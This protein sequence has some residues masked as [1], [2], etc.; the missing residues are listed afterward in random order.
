MKVLLSIMACSLLLLFAQTASN[1][2]FFFVPQDTA[3][4]D[5]TAAKKKEPERALPLKPERKIEFTTDEGT[6]LS[7]DVSPDGKTIVFELLGDLYTLP[8][9]GGKATPITSGLA[10]DSQPRFSPDGKRIVFVTDRGGS[11]NLY[12][13]EA[14]KSIVDTTAAVDSTGLKQLTKGDKAMYASPEWTPDGKY[15]VASKGS[16][17]GVYH[18]HLYHVDGGSGIDLFAK[19]KERNALGAA[20]GKDDRY[21]YFSTK[22]GRFQYNMPVFNWQM[23]IYDRETGEVFPLTGETGGAV[24]PCL[25]PDGN[26]LVYAT[27]KDAKTA[28]KVRNLQSGF[29]QWLAYPVTRD[30]QES[31][32][33][34]D[35]MP[36]YAFT[37][38]SKAI[39]A[40]VD[41]KI[42]RIEVPSGQHTQIPFGVD[43]ELELGPLSH[44]EKQVED[45]PVKVRQIR[46]A[47]IS[48]DGTHL[49]FTALHDL[50]VRNFASGKMTQLAPMAAGQ[51]GPAWSPDSKSLAFVTWSEAEGGAVYKVAV[52]GGRAQKLSQIAAYYTDPVWTPD[53]KEIVVAKGPW[54]QRQDLTIF[55][56]RGG[57]GLDLVRIPANGG[58]DALIAPLKGVRPHF[59]DKPDRIY[60]YEGRDGLVSMRLDG[61]DRKV[62]AKVTGPMPPFGG[63]EPTTAD[64]VIMGA[65]GEHVLAQVEN[66][67][68]RITVPKVGGEPPTVSILSPESATFP[69]EKLSTVGALFMNFGPNDKEANWSL[70]N[71]FFRYNFDRAKIFADSIKAVAAAKKDKS[72]KEDN[73]DEKKYEPFSI[74][75]DLEAPRLKGN[76]TVVLRGAKILTMTPGAA[77]DGVIENGAVVIKDNRID[78]VGASSEITTPDGAREIDVNGKFILPGFVDTHAHMW[79]AWGV[80]RGVVWEYLA[81]VAYGVLTTRDPQTSTTDVLTY[82]DLVETGELLGPRVY[83]TGPGVFATDGIKSLKDAQ[84]VLKR[85]SEYYKINTIKQYVAGDRNTR[86]W[87]IMAAKEQGLIPTTEGALDMKLDLSQIIDGYPGN[88]HSFPIMP[89]YK[90]V[91]ELVAKSHTFYTPT[92][93]VS[94]GGPWAENYYYTNTD[95]HDDAKLRK[96]VPHNEIDKLTRRRP[97]FHNDE[98]VYSQLAAQAKK[99]VEAGGRVC[100]GS[101]GQLQGLGYHWELWA[102]QSG[103][104]SEMDALRCATIFGAESIG[105]DKDL[106]TIA[107]GK[108]ADLIVLEK[109]PL[110][111]IHNT[112]TIQYV[113]KNGLLYD[114]NS[115]NQIW[116]EEKMLPKPY[117]WDHEPMTNGK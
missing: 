113:M 29:E 102:V 83:Y 5:T 77:N 55:T 32:F 3:K 9:A 8:I 107:S 59:A 116:P 98:H 99:V 47:R 4:T 46:W 81:N 30:D 112:N 103:G 109:N 28:F 93:L 94:Y 79:P 85:Y 1:A 39:I 114:A 10:F 19:E 115:L 37:A 16:G 80:H 42:Y 106:G 25:S 33:T 75:I 50:Y 20:F 53:G 105:F 66:H 76:G 96:F 52:S 110:D 51:F 24:R 100:I 91:V 70:G 68:Y 104:M 111:D 31:R 17:L 56:N 78:K 95:V 58:P 6:W 12:L 64:E 57:Q 88:E 62:H 45:G 22:Q 38:D 74:A 40:S 89:L 71:H 73:D 11:E 97:W 2:S 65:D 86:Q 117:W 18:L 15:I 21:V 101:H 35:L 36:G 43:V 27:R 34:R 13:L 49:A 63:E 84:S 69:V 44:S 41:G 72:K 87:I 60:V 90:D 54:Q 7:L 26:W 92:L 108:F 67:V 82:S 48:P 23:A 14:G 61:T